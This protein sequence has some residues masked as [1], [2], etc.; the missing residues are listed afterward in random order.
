MEECTDARNHRSI[1]DI[2]FKFNNK[3]KKL[4]AKAR[5]FSEWASNSPVASLF[6][7]VSNLIY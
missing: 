1:V 3:S 7:S 2:K 6:L 4:V 5:V